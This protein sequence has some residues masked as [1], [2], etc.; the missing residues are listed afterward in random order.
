MG[1]Y[2]TLSRCPVQDILSF[3]CEARNRVCRVLW[4]RLKVSGRPPP[5]LLSCKEDSWTWDGTG[6]GDRRKRRRTHQSPVPK[7]ACLERVISTLSGTSDLV[8]V[9]PPCRER[10]REQ[11]HQVAGVQRDQAG[12]VRGEY[13]PR[14]LRSSILI[15]ITPDYRLNV[16]PRKPIC[17]H[18]PRPEGTLGNVASAES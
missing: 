8:Q 14:A 18:I 17:K 15:G 7:K 5:V 13:F 6:G 2:L 10:Q 4:L 3:S 1:I 9:V 11:R 12:P 16:P